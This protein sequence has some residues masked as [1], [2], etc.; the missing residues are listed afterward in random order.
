MIPLT[1]TQISE[2]VDGKVI[3]DG[4]KLITGAAFFDP[5][6]SMYGRKR[7][8]RTC[9]ANDVHGKCDEKCKRYDLEI[10]VDV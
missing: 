7:C 2:I 6:F 9:G 3:G 5:G 4:S 10:N 1:V 8:C